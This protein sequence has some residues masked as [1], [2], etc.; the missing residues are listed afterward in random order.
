[1]FLRPL[2]P[3]LLSFV[4]GILLSDTALHEG[5]GVGLGLF[6][7]VLVFLLL[8]FFL[9]LTFRLW[10]LIALF[11]SAGMFLE[12][13][14]RP[15]SDLD[16][17]AEQRAEVT[18]MG[19]VLEPWSQSGK[20]GRV[21]VKVESMLGSWGERGRG[22][23]IM[24]TV[25]RPAE[26]VFPGQRILFPAKL[27]PFQN[28]NNPGRYDYERTMR[29]NGFACAAS[30]SEGRRIVPMGRG[31][32][33]F[34]FDELE[35][36]R[37]PIRSL[38]RERLPPDEAALFQA[39]ILGEKQGIN[40]QL[41]E[42]F[43]K[44]GLGHV[45]A[46]S[47]LHVALVAWFAFTICVSLLSLSYRL[48]LRVEIRK[49][50]AA[51]TCIPVLGYACLAGFEVS[52]QRAM[53]M[54][55]AFLC[56]MILGKEKEMWS[57]FALAGLVVLAL[58]P[59][60]LFSI[61]FQ[62]SFCAVAGI[63][64]L[65]PPLRRM[66]RFPARGEKGKQKL[67]TRFY[68]YFAD[69]A[70]VT[71]SATIFLLPLTSFYFHRLSLM[72]IPANLTV[73]PVLG[74]LVLPL[75]LCA[76][77][78][79]PLSG[80]LAV[81]LLKAA[82]WGL[83]RMMDYVKYWS[84]W[85]WSEAW[86][87]TPNGPEVLLLY[88]LMFSLY[89]AKRTAWARV[90]LIVVLLLFAGDGFYWIQRNLYNPYLRVT[91]LDVGQGNAALVQF[92]GKE[93]MLIDG[94]GFPGSQFDVGRMIV[95]PFLLRSKITR[96]DY[97]VLT[98]P[99]SDHMDGLCFIAA[100]FKPKEFWHN[101]ERAETAAYRKLMGILRSRKVPIVSPMNWKGERLMEGVKV[102]M[103]HPR[104]DDEES[105]LKTNDRSLVL[106]LSYKDRS[107]LFPG[108]LE[109]AGE[110]KVILRSGA[111]LESDVLL[112]PHH[113]S[114]SSSSWPFLKRVRPRVCVISAGVGNVFHFP[115]LQVLERLESLGCRTF[116]TDRAGAVEV[117][118]G[119]KGGEV[120]SYLVRKEKGPEPLG[121]FLF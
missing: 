106:K 45:L 92:P 74:L 107:F 91:Y 42:P 100:H 112:A 30:V 32:L 61:S 110:E 19:T 95:G 104:K 6:F 109:K 77:V 44:A 10:G 93:R 29:L 55:L 71:L 99:Q 43:S 7:I 90:A 17:L 119:P 120:R 83:E 23:K 27:R 11:L 79:L 63:L 3:I 87:I 47:G 35:V 34:P 65:G 50:A 38:L 68:L 70:A 98:H 28:F 80:S 105:S 72:V 108:D 58:D 59:S 94:G 76:A 117:V 12:Y 81:I 53:I 16:L 41:R 97:L 88:A 69:L 67:T 33:G 82:A 102:A 22:E 20:M 39:L 57:T 15:R 89:F 37:S 26:E 101:G 8:L 5:Y 48:A 103:L 36:F 113:G 60:A 114:G 13:H 31:H 96:I 62:L 54:V 116:R 85:S 121:P 118:V 66:L 78:S 51:V 52:C 25:F 4:G 64:W 56:S 9:P 75:G 18:I 46:V 21:V 2:I 14:S 40:L 115:N 84:S 24:V 49:I 1:M 111:D 86:V 73:L